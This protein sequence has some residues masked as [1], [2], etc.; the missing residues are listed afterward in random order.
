MVGLPV[1]MDYLSSD[2]TAIRYK[3]QVLWMISC[4]HIMEQ[5]GQKPTMHVF[6]TVHHVRLCMFCE[7]CQVAALTAKSAVSDCIFVLTKFIKQKTWNFA[8]ADK[9]TASDVTNK[10]FHIV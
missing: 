9:K 4:F 1:A 5:I 2:C 3:L 7:V 8:T 6:H 10:Q